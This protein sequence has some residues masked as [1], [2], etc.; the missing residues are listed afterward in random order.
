MLFRHAHYTFGIS[1]AHKI[2]LKSMI[3]EYEETEKCMNLIEC[4]S[5]IRGVGYIYLFHTVDESIMDV[6]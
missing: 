5:D 6:K 2:G 1:I 3:S 4:Y